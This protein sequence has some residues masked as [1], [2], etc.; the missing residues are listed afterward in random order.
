MI[1]KKEVKDT[2]V[3]K[4][5]ADSHEGKVLLQVWME[6]GTRDWLAKQAEADK[7]TVAAYVRVLFERLKESPKLLKQIEAGA[8]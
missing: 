5:D 6:E 4:S 2:K 8:K 1:K 7:R 3:D